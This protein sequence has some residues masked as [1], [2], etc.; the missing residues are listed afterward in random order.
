MD[1]ENKGW[2]SQVFE[3]ITNGFTNVLASIKQHGWKTALYTFI[4][5]GLLWSIV[6]NPIRIGDMVQTQWEK[7]LETEKVVNDEKTE[8]SISRREKANFFV[9][10]LMLNVIDK[11]D[12]VNRVLLLEKHNGS[13]SLKGVDFL[14]SSCTY[15]LVNNDI[16]DPLFL[17]EDLQKQTNLNLLGSNLI[18]TLKH[19]E[20]VYFDDLE[21]QKNNQCRLLRK[22]YNGGDKQ[23]IIFSFKDNNHRPIILLVISGDN[24][25][26]KSIEEYIGQFKKQIEELLID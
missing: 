14:Y 22:L 26:D 16:T 23:C 18:Q 13:Q 2:I 5:V 9:S 4:I 19:K 17:Y 21:K 15:E 3:S 6:I 10:E 12:N 20:Y 8:E 11:F 25:N 24:L 1:N 7:H